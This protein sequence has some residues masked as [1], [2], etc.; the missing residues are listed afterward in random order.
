MS[1]PKKS[2]LRLYS[3]SVGKTYFR[4]SHGFQV[5]Q[6][7]AQVMHNGP[8]FSQHAVGRVGD[9]EVLMLQLEQVCQV[10]EDVR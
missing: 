9:I 5:A 6:F 4:S 10:T 1:M 8:R 7:V 3:K 2:G